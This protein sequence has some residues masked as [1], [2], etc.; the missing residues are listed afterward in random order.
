MDSGAWGGD[1]E[2]VASE[3]AAASAAV[4]VGAGAVEGLLALPPI[5]PDNIE[6]NT[7]GL[8]LYSRVMRGSVLRSGSA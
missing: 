3:G 4:G 2:V 8:A 7:E 6:V 1:D 5:K